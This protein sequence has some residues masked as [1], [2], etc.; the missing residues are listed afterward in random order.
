M[1]RTALLSIL[2]FTLSL[3]IACDKAD[4]P[5]AKAPAKS[6]DA[7]QP[8]DASKPADSDKPADDAASKS[9]PEGYV[10]HLQDALA[11]LAAGAGITTASPP[12]Y[13]CGVKYADAGQPATA[14]IG[15]PAPAFSLPDLD[16]KTVSLAD[17]AGKTVVLEW[18]NPGCPFVKYA[19]GDGPLATMAAE[20]SKGGIVWLAINSGA[21]GKQ[22]TGVERN[23]EAAGE[24]KL[25]HPILL[26]EDGKVGHAYGA[27]ST[28][29]MFVI[30]GAGKLVYA[31][32]LDNAPLGRVDG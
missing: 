17:F 21:P 7:S 3:V 2:A 30:D 8:A 26:D 32:G 9:V 31:G 18:F 29:H 28:P 20:Q 11:Q 13:G 6:D 16:G 23:R 14:K 22:G 1:S 15:E 5:D 27:T 12:A 19:H 10:A 25:E 4:Q 24:W